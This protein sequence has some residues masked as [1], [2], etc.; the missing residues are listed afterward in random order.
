MSFEIEIAPQRQSNRLSSS[1]TSVGVFIFPMSK[2][3]ETIRV[4]EAQADKLHDLADRGEARHE[5]VSR[6][7]DAYDQQQDLLN[8]TDTANQSLADAL[9]RANHTKEMTV[10]TATAFSKIEDAHLKLSETHPDWPTPE[11][12]DE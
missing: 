10:T 7:L 1:N 9:D 5:V 11:E 4:T 12:T 6:L 8:V 3:T 2:A